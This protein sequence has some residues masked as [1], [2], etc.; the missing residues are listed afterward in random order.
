MCGIAGYVGN[1]D[2]Q[3]LKR[4]C[5]TMK[6]R[7]PDDEG[8][9]VGDGVGLGH[10]RLSIIDLAT[11]HQPMCNEDQTVWIAFNGEIYNYQELKGTLK[12]K[13]HTFETD[14]DTEVIIHAY[15][16][17]GSDCPQYLR[18]MFAF[19]I[20][21][22]NTRELF[23]A[24]DRL[25]I[26][27]FFYCQVGNEFVFASELKALLEHPRINPTLN[28]SAF[29]EYMSFGF[30]PG[31]Q[32]IYDTLW[33]LPPGGWVCV[34]DGKPEFGQYWHL[35]GVESECASFAE[36]KEQL[37]RLLSDSVRMTEDLGT[38][39]HL[40]RSTSLSRNLL[41]TV[42]YHLDQPMSDAA[43]I[44][45]YQM[46]ELT[47][48]HIKVVLTGE[49]A[50]ECFSG[51][52]HMKYL[53]YLLTSIAGPV[54]RLAA[55]GARLA[56]PGIARGKRSLDLM[57]NGRTLPDMM[58]IVFGCFSLREKKALYGPAMLESLDDLEAKHKGVIESKLGR[59][60]AYQ[61]VVSFYLQTYLPDDLLV[62]TDRMTMA[63]GIEAR[64]P[65]LDHELVQFALALPA[66]WKVKLWTDKYILRQVS[67]DRLP[68]AIWKRP[69][70]GF[71]VPMEDWHRN[72]VGNARE[73]VR[74]LLARAG[75][76][77]EKNWSNWMDRKRA[78]DG[79]QMQW[80]SLLF[81]EEWAAAFVDNIEWDAADL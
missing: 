46:A 70:H 67:R 40:L 77:N 47:R 61:Q 63:H 5:E 20:W 34:K 23:C 24:R 49:G 22:A 75:L 32:T 28:L 7:G 3:L 11:G 74:R 29:H 16:E 57:A 79:D 44:P 9:W 69:K 45:T 2:L 4:M 60:S 54:M 27:P 14:S 51:Y 6:H 56:F 38:K 18:G 31:P 65:Y 66:A 78:P 8:F 81:F 53:R 36:A 64:V 33:S 25:G 62:K 48:R 12:R 76:I 39:H 73:E 52:Q 1:G 58:D 26:K 59:G 21:N 80:R 19:A 35:E 15:E 30:V 41:P 68:K 17:Y 10:R 42:A 71:Y 37:L 50:D 13:G 43:A 72:R 55:R